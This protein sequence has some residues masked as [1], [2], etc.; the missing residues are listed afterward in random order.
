MSSKREEQLMERA[1][2]LNLEVIKSKA[3]R[4]MPD[5]HQ[6]YRIVDINNTVLAGENFDM[7]LEDV[8]KFIQERESTP[9]SAM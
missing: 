1:K 6:Q 3:K 9:Q 7:S 5:D 4:R 2:R 8:E